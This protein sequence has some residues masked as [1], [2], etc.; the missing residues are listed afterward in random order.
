MMVRLIMADCVV[1]DQAYS[2]IQLSGRTK[3]CSISPVGGF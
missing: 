3:P 1:A 2:A